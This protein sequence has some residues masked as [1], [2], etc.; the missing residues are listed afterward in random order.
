MSTWVLL[1]GLTREAAH[2]GE[3]PDRLRQQ[4]PD[5]R[6]LTP[7]LPGNG[8]R[9][10]EW[11]P[12]TV[13]GLAAA[14]RADMD[15]EAVQ[16]PVYLLAMSLGAMVATEWAHTAPH[17]VAASVLINTSLRPFS[18]FHH[19]LQV[20]N[21]GR[22]A[23]LLRPSTSALAT[24]LAIFE[25]TCDHREHM[26]ATVQQWA[27]I[28]QARPVSRGNA[29]RQLAAAARYRAPRRAP[30]PPTLLLGSEGDGLV[31]PRCSKA[32]AQAWGCPLRM[33]PNAGHDL[34]HDDPQWVIEQVRDWLGGCVG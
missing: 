20:H 18:P 12:A 6:V 31:D 3:F 28:R 4:W 33:H 7:D 25:M 29:L 19:R 11:S 10:G 5:A 26:R 15:C 34:P 32:I 1:R 13:A 24:E 23:A 9:C 2:W 27:A 16:G 30:Q 17:E 22:I 21:Y 14:V 8:R